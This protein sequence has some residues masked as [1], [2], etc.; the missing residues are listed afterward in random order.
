MLLSTVATPAST[1]ALKR[2]AR[3][4]DE[5]LRLMAAGVL[6]SRNDTS[7]LNTVENVLL[8]QPAGINDSVLSGLAGGLKGIRD[9]QAIPSLS[10]LLKARD[11]RV[12]QSASAALRNMKA[13][14]AIEPLVEA[15]EDSDRE[16]RYNAVIGLAEITGQ[17]EWGPSVE[18]FQREEQKFLTHWIEWAR[19]R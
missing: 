5:Q 11:A 18:L 17:Y 6:L 13:A 19:S 7:M 14:A 2:A 9:P 3:S 10:R 8:N 12:W 4:L 16:V 15:L 1:A